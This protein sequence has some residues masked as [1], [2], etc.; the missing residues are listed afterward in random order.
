MSR[1]AWGMN[2]CATHI[3]G[4]M[5]AAAFHA[6]MMGALGFALVQTAPNSLPII[7]PLGDQATFDLF[8]SD[9]SVRF[10]QNI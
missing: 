10:V 6:D 2:T 8:I 1:R 7:M 5:S 3:H 4:F 9:P